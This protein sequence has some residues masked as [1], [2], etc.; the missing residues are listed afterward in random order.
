LALAADG[1]STFG[2]LRALISERLALSETF[3]VLTLRVDGRARP[4]D[5]DGDIFAPAPTISVLVKY[6]PRF[7]LVEPGN[8][9]IPTREYREDELVKCLY[10]DVEKRL[11]CSVTLHCGDMDLDGLRDVSLASSTLLTQNSPI[12]VE[13]PPLTVTFQLENDRISRVV[14][15]NLTIGEFASSSDC[16]VCLCAG[17]T[18]R[19]QFGTPETRVCPAA[20]QFY[21]GEEHL[22]ES[23]TF[24]G[25]KLAPDSSISIRVAPIHTF[26]FNGE[27]TDRPILP[28]RTL[29][30]AEDD[31]CTVFG[32]PVA[33]TLADGFAAPDML[34]ADFAAGRP[35]P[36]RLVHRMTQGY[37]FQVPY[38]PL[39]TF[40]LSPEMTILEAKAIVCPDRSP[41]TFKMEFQTRVFSDTDTLE[42]VVTTAED[43]ITIEFLDKHG[44]APAAPGRCPIVRTSQRR[45]PRPPPKEMSLK[46]REVAF[47]FPEPVPGR[48]WLSGIQPIFTFTKGA[49]VGDAFRVIASI[50]GVSHPDYGLFDRDRDLP[51]ESELPL[52]KN[53][54][55]SVVRRPFTDVRHIR[56]AM[57]GRPDLVLEIPPETSVSAAR[58]TVSRHLGTTA[59]I[60]LV[61]LGQV[62]ADGDE[63]F[64]DLELE[65]D[66]RILVFVPDGAADL[67]E[68][69]AVAARTSVFFM[70]DRAPISITGPPDMTVSIAKRRLAVITGIPIGRLSIM[71]DGKRRLDDSE[72]LTEGAF[73]GSSFLVDC[74]DKSDEPPLNDTV[75]VDEMILKV[76][77]DLSA[78]ATDKADLYP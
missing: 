58:L 36:L 31:L 48:P 75:V 63:R 44:A 56:F 67:P 4:S 35:S 8:Q 14:K 29:A 65:P 33:F 49:K 57:P 51:L 61:Y 9:K 34:F 23:Q 62:L 69:P 53:Y 55:L 47:E 72:L 28:M 60:E 16:C 3:V 24:S 40:L 54:A 26:E 50:S 42:K 10:A 11:K 71:G 45:P 18:T 32:T 15:R 77:G 21:R 20:L 41:K 27:L 74:S 1:A 19:Y 73:D 38:A 2:E 66:S 76:K 70:R 64:R 39:A 78:D 30:G 37:I 25:L 17:S 68:L 12:L 13:R 52:P 7:L 59:E 22:P 43:P 6:R 46:S 5:R